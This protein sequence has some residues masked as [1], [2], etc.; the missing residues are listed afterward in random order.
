MKS[1]EDKKSEQV[2]SNLTP[3]R[4]HRNTLY[5]AECKTVHF[6]VQLTELHAA[7]HGK[8][9]TQNYEPAHLR[10]CVFLCM[11]PLAQCGRGVYMRSYT[12]MCLRHDLLLQ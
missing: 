5:K 12:C 3:L 7:P 6:T 1:W 10:G 11:S 4:A 9:P 2:N 8:M